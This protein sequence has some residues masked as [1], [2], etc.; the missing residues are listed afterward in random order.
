MGEYGIFR[1]AEDLRDFILSCISCEQERIERTE[2]WLHKLIHD[3][4]WK[5]GVNEKAIEQTREAL[6]AQRSR[7]AG[8]L[9]RHAE[10]FGPG[11]ALVK[12]GR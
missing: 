6:Q 2:E 1:N 9:R 8:Y 11:L 7:L 3:P 12:S 10:H 5:D 4:L